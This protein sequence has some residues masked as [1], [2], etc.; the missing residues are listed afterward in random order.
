ME[1]IISQICATFPDIQQADAIRIL[2][3]LGF[4]YE[5]MTQENPSYRLI[6]GESIFIQSCVIDDDIE[7][8]KI[9]NQERLEL[10]AMI[11]RN[12]TSG[13]NVAPT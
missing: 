11:I 8:N 10:T 13:T 5:D 12:S 3:F 9:L 2:D 7:R 1:S 4:S 6:N